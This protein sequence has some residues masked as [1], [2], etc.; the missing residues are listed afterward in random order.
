MY[1]IEATNNLDV[2]FIQVGK[3]SESG[4]SFFLQGTVPTIEKTGVQGK[5]VLFAAVKNSPVKRFTIDSHKLYLD[6]CDT[7][8][9]AFVRWM[10]DDM[11]TVT[12]VLQGNC[13][14]GVS[15]SNEKGFYGLWNFWL[16]KQGIAN[17]ISIPQLE[18]DGYTIDYNTK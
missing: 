11:K 2:E 9:S 15:T 5:H 13:N 4:H 10:L 14:T 1:M 6:S 17:L 16:N 12:T 7:Y 8:H 3:Q 18:K